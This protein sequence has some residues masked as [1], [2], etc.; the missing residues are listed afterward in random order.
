MSAARIVRC[1]AALVYVLRAVEVRTNIAN[2]AK[3]AGP[4][5]VRD[6]RNTHIAHYRALLHHV[7]LER[8]LQKLLSKAKNQTNKQS[9]RSS[10]RV[11]R[12]CCVR[13]LS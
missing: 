12:E 3:A 7:A 9:N 4:R 6:E 1:L 2:Q 8:S 10:S 13:V 5:L 11:L